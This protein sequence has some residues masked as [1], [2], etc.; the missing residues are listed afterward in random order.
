MKKTDVYQTVMKNI[1]AA[2][3]KGI[4][5]WRKPFKISFSPIPINFSTGKVCRGIN[6]FLMNLAYFQHGYP[7]KAWLTNKFLNI[8]QMTY[9]FRCPNLRLFNFFFHQ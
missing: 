3:E 6:V 4:I 2:M 8:Y 9:P 1:L 7:K 5:P